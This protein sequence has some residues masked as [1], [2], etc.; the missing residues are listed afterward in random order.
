MFKPTWWGVE[1]WRLDPKSEFKV[2][3]MLHI[4]SGLYTLFF[5]SRL[6][7]RSKGRAVFYLAVQGWFPC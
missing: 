1:G 6:C 4:I 2:T 3:F 7:G 5:D